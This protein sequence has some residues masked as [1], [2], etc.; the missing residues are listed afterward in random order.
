VDEM[1]NETMRE[2]EM[3][4]VAWKVRSAITTIELSKS[5]YVDETTGRT[6]CGLSLEDRKL[7]TISYR[8]WDHCSRCAKIA[9]ARKGSEA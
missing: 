3:R 9:A 1:G 4:S 6:L 8:P 5:H 2:D 7:V